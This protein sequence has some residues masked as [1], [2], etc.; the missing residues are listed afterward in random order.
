MKHI[1]NYSDYLIQRN[2]ALLE[3]YKKQRELHPKRHLSTIC[4][5]IINMPAKRFFIGEERACDVLSAMIR[6]KGKY[7]H[8]EPRRRMYEELLARTL[9]IRNKNRKL[10]L[11]KAV[12]EAVNSEAPEY[13][14]TLPTAIS[15]IYNELRMK[16]KRRRAVMLAKFGA[17]PDLVL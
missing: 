1:G 11:E 10:P 4:E 16:A 5:T 2:A 12:F 17:K 7:I 13:Y 3:A 14:I 8:S 15:I 6:G 9:R